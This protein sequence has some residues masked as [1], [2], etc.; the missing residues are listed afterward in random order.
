[1][2]LVRN[3]SY[4]KENHAARCV[5]QAKLNQP[6]RSSVINPPLQICL[7]VECAVDGKC[8]Q[9]Q[10]L[11]TPDSP[12]CPYCER[13]L[14]NE[15][16]IGFGPA[17]SLAELIPF[18]IDIDPCFGIHCLPTFCSPG[19]V[20]FTPKGQCCQICVSLKEACTSLECEREGKECKAVLEHAQC[21]SASV[22]TTNPCAVTLCKAGT[23]CEDIGGQAVCIPQFPTQ[24][25][26]FPMQCEPGTV[27]RVIGGDAQACVPIIEEPDSCAAVLCEKG[28]TCKVINSQAICVPVAPIPECRRLCQPGTVCKFIEGNAVCVPTKFA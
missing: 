13:K 9:G 26:P 6:F 14:E 12:C 22:Q 8:P 20:R 16:G 10:Q 17:R 4:A 23:V 24:E 1:M 21:V 28:S 5:K 7:D 2:Q 11:V 18:P 3:L 15:H 19:E 27:C 25:C